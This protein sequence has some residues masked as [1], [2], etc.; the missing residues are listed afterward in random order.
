MTKDAST[1]RTI[2]SNPEMPKETNN[3]EMDMENTNVEYHSNDVYG[4]LK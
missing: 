3:D 4:D 2:L 1:S